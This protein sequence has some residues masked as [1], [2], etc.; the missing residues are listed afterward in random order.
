MVELLYGAGLREGEGLGLQVQDMCVN[1]DVAQVF[2]CQMFAEFG[3]HLHV[4]RRMNSNRA[5]AKSSLE[6]I[7]PMMPRVLVAYQDWQAWIYDHLPEAVESRFLLVSLSGPTKG[8]SWTIAGLQSMWNQHVKTIPGL[9]RS[10][11]HLLRHTYASEL[12][13]AG[14]DA[15]IIQK[16][17]G[18]RSPTSTQVYTHPRSEQ[19]V[20]AVR[21]LASWRSDLVAAQ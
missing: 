19:M 8:R 20:A 12:K 5:I 2:E 4:V 17:L 11:P 21:S 16:L 10:Y 18:H 9:E 1:K 14:V 13:D 15:F 6:R 7:V 3:P